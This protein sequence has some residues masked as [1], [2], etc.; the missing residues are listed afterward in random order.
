MYRVH[1]AP[2]RQLFIPR[3][4]GGGLQRVSNQR[5]SAAVGG[6]LHHRPDHL[7]DPGDHG[8]APRHHQVRGE[9]V[10]G[11]PHLSPGPPHT[12]RDGDAGAAQ[13][14]GGPGP[15]HLLDLVMCHHW[16]V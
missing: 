14:S 3:M 5:D 11:D 9:H 15:G 6:H 8:Q 2:D 4:R 16:P 12:Q 7:G 1:L 13:P 10:G